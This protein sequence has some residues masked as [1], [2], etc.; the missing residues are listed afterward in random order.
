[1]TDSPK[2]KLGRKPFAWTPEIEAEILDR[3]AGGESIVD[4]CG[5]GKDDWLPSD[6]TLYSRI[7]NDPEFFQR[8]ARAREAQGHREADEIKAI[9]DAATVEDVHVARLKIDARK[10]R[11]SKM[12]PKSYGDKQIIEG[13][14]KDGAV[15]IDTPEL[16]PTETARRVAFILAS[17]MQEKD[18]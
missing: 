13:S 9:A 7:S 5:P 17:A 3:I 14:G 4:I 8:Y 2:A 15:L 10:W 6:R 11:A 1:M 12:A 18:Q 16:T